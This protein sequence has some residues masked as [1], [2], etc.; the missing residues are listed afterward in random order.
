MQCQAAICSECSVTCV[1]VICWANVGPPMVW[2]IPVVP[3]ESVGEG[4]PLGE[5]RAEH[6]AAEPTAEPTSC[7]APEVQRG[8]TRCT[9]KFSKAAP[10]ESLGHLLCLRNKKLR[11]WPNFMSKHSQRSPCKVNEEMGH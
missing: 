11:I 3:A 9:A 7:T 10:A 2:C 6:R 1:I 4:W 8:S 5:P